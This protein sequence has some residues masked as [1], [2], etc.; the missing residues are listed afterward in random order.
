MD[1]QVG[2]DND[3]QVNTVVSDRTLNM[4]C[5][6]DAIQLC[7]GQHCDNPKLKLCAALRFVFE[8]SFFERQV[9]MLHSTLATC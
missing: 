6:D 9:L 4:L 3:E 7:S 5:K 1:G 8:F 2:D